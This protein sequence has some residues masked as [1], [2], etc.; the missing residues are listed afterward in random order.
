MLAYE[1]VVGNLNTSL[2]QCAPCLIFMNER[3]PSTDNSTEVD[4]FAGL[5]VFVYNIADFDPRGMYHDTIMPP[6]PLS[7]T[8]EELSNPRA[9]FE[10]I[11]TVGGKDFE[12]DLVMEINWFG[13]PPEKDSPI[14]G[15]KPVTGWELEDRIEPE[16]ISPQL[17]KALLLE[18]TT[19]E[20][21]IPRDTQFAVIHHRLI[22]DRL[23]VVN[24]SNG[25]ST[26][27]Y[28]QHDDPHWRQ[29]TKK[30]AAEPLEQEPEFETVDLVPDPL[31]E[32]KDRGDRQY[33]GETLAFREAML[34]A[35]NELLLQLGTDMDLEP[36]IPPGLLMMRRA[37]ETDGL[38]RMDVDIPPDSPRQAQTRKIAEKMRHVDTAPLAV[39]Q[40]IQTTEAI[41]RMV[42]RNGKR[43]TL[44][45]VTSFRKSKPGMDQLVRDIVTDLKFTSLLDDEAVPMSHTQVTQSL[46]RLCKIEKA[47]ARAVIKTPWNKVGPQA[48]DTM[49]NVIWLRFDYRNI[50]YDIR[51]R[52]RMKIYARQKYLRK[53]VLERTYA[54]LEKKGIMRP[55]EYDPKFFKRLRLTQGITIDRKQ[56]AKEMPPLSTF[57]DRIGLK[58]DLEDATSMEPSGLLLLLWKSLKYAQPHQWKKG[59]TDTISYI[60]GFYTTTADKKWLEMGDHL[61]R[62]RLSGEALESTDPLPHLQADLANTEE[63]QERAAATELD[64]R[65]E[66]Y[67][68]TDINKVTEAI[69][70]E[71]IPE[72]FESNAI[73]FSQA[74]SGIEL[75]DLQDRILAL[76]PIQQVVALSRLG[77]MVPQEIFDKALTREKRYEEESLWRGLRVKSIIYALFDDNSYQYYKTVKEIAL[78][79]Q[80]SNKVN[81]DRTAIRKARRSLRLNRE[82]SRKKA[83]ETTTAPDP[84]ESIAKK[85]IASTQTPRKVIRWWKDTTPFWGEHKKYMEPRSA[86]EWETENSE[87]GIDQH[88]LDYYPATS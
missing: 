34:A 11:M 79:L 9:V 26:C 30:T 25:V 4:L 82:R 67:T 61:G 70:E 78:A 85:P 32:S 57:I 49:I 76:S 19:W 83:Q 46:Q 45:Q 52:A 64:R 56:I 53:A 59:A 10:K 23:Y 8:P 73:L 43:H 86:V 74:V 6:Y 47:F 40:V 13:A 60:E 35:D 65:G 24:L 68:N 39:T 29:T 72:V 77:Y 80:D 44:E 81:V 54:W 71:E 69:Q 51:S 12:E 33:S 87:D 28:H 21:I 2:I 18:N 31:P 36:R 66:V 62:L 7:E 88:V 27:L 63:F 20:T 5:T 38:R 84:E 1:R 3:Q 22:P 75:R 50:M 55:Q 58:H 17:T 37:D 16:K 15:S 14:S 42:R 48:L 41:R